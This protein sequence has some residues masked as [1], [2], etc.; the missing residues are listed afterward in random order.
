MGADESPVADSGSAAGDSTPGDSPDG[1]SGGRES[2]GEPPHIHGIDCRTGLAADPSS[3]DYDP[4]Q[5]IGHVWKVDGV[6]YR[7]GRNGQLLQWRLVPTRHH[8]SMTGRWNFAKEPSRKTKID[9]RTERVNAKM[10]ELGIGPANPHRPTTAGIEDLPREDQVRIKLRQI[11]RS[12]SAQVTDAPTTLTTVADVH[13]LA[14]AIRYLD[15]GRD[16]FIAFVQGGMLE[17]LPE[18]TAWFRVYADL[19]PYERIRAN[20]DDI[21]A[22]AGVRPSK[23]LSEIVSMVMER[24]RDVGNLAAAVM[25]P[26][27]VAALAKSG[28]TID[29]KNPEIHHKDRIAF[30]QGMGTLPLPKG[31]V[32]NNNLNASAAAAAIAAESPSMPSFAEDMRGVTGTRTVGQRALAAS[33]SDDLDWKPPARHAQ[34]AVIDATAAEPVEDDE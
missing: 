11:K 9:Q 30:L 8:K 14:F 13:S 23:L 29:G 16:A 22:A 20:L 2:S 21:C 27:V 4:T 34:P 25:H 1:S 32:I 17:E 3:P 12:I 33:T 26:Q 10:Q 7:R 15:G 28:S 24:G 19:T 18:S 6:S 5:I 31:V